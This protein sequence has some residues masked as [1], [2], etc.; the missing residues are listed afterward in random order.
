M[1]TASLIV[2]TLAL[3]IGVACFASLARLHRRLDRLEPRP[4]HAVAR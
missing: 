2:A 1:I 4:R 3:A